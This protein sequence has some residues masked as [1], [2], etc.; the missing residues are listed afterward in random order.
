MKLRMPE[1]LK[2][3]GT[4][5]CCYV[6]ASVGVGT[7][8]WPRMWSEWDWH[9]WIKPQIDYMSGNGVGVNAIRVQGAAYAVKNGTINMDTYLSRWSQL[10]EYCEQR[11]LYVYPCGCTLDS[12]TDINLPADQMG[13]VFGQI[14]KHLQ[15]YDSVIGFDMIQETANWGP[16]TYTATIAKLAALIG[17]IKQYG[18]TAP[19]TCSSSEFV[20]SG[21]PW[22]LEAA[23]HLDFI[24]IHCYYHSVPAG[25]L[26]V[27]LSAAPGKDIIVGEV[28]AEA[29]W[30]TTAEQL[31]TIREVLT[32]AN[33]GNPNV[34]GALVWSAADPANPAVIT[35]KAWGQFDYSYVPRQDRLQ[36]LRRFTG[37]SVEKCNQIH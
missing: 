28:G 1:R 29:S 34:R 10:V 33:S 31:R 30:S 15:Q 27:I 26:D 11:G 37:G 3:W 19:I 36:L 23:P 16:A 8:A 22:V 35:G 4:N 13:A 2:L 14:F 25:A 17:V 6:D 12:D 21:F 24:D 5:L 18:V 32:M 20:D 9:N 7:G